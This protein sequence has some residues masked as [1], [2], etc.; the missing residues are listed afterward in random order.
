MAEVFLRPCLSIGSGEGMSA[1]VMRDPWDDATGPDPLQRDQ[2]GRPIIMR[3]DLPGGTCPEVKYCRIT[4]G[5]GHY[6]R[7][8]RFATILEDGIGLANWSVRH[9]ALAAARAAP[10]TRALLASCW[11]PSKDNPCPE[12]D[13]YIDQA[14]EQAKR[15]GEGKIETADYGTAVHRFAIP[16]SPPHAPETLAP[17]IEAHR[18]ELARRR[19]RILES[20][21]FIVHDTLRVA[22]TLDD[23]ILTGDDGRVVIG[24]KK[25]GKIRPLSQAVQ[26]A[27]YAGGARYNPATGARSVLHRRLDSRHGYIEHLP[28]GQGTC[29]MI[30]VDLKT[31]GIY[32]EMA[33]EVHEARRTAGTLL[34]DE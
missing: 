8:S 23:L 12:L 31:A 3:P 13:D 28:L 1:G 11:Y 20:E 15:D 29:R 16:D 18:I 34:V 4:T 7:A 22:G 30:G 26:L 6:M 14:L 27:I 25:T 2:W 33:R 5:H 21:I 10:S 32:A 19:W 9:V 17:D 24:D